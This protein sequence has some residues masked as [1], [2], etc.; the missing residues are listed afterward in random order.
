LPLFLSEKVKKSVDWELPRSLYSVKMLR[1]DPAILTFA[2]GITAADYVSGLFT[3]AVNDVPA[4]TETSGTSQLA[5]LVE[6]PPRFVPFFESFPRDEGYWG[7]FVVDNLDGMP[8]VWAIQ[9]SRDWMD[10]EDDQLSWYVYIRTSDRNF[11]ARTDYVSARVVTEQDRLSFVTENI[12]GVHYEFDG[13]FMYGGSSFTNGEKVLR[14][15]LQKL[16]NGKVAARF[17][18][19]FA[20]TEPYCTR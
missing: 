20:Y 19:T 17:T 3:F 10:A 14:G 12:R 13:R 15:S 5:E 8:E 4:I 9:L 6:A 11:D 16:V 2:I 18:S 1:V 7:W